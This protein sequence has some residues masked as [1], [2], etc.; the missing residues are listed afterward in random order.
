MAVEVI[1]REQELEELGRFLDAVDGSPL[2]SCW[3]GRRGSARLCSGAPV[4][5]L[6]VRGASGS[7]LRFRRRRRH[8]SRFRLSSICSLRCSPMCCRRCR[9]RSGGRSR[10]LFCSPSPRGRFRTRTLWTLRCSACCVFSRVIPCLSLWMM[11]SGSTE[12]PQ[13]RS[14][15]LCAACVTS[16][17]RFCSP[18]GCR[19]EGRAGSARSRP[20]T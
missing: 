13:P 3:R 17:S 19:R 10:S 11:C 8:G 7:S 12:L 4:S 6:P 1:G 2:R 9:R 15:S 20:R 5:I 18:G 16:R 14:C